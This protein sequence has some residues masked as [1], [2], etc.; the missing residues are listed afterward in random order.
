MAKVTIEVPEEVVNAI[1][2]LAA[3]K[4]VTY[5]EFCYVAF[6]AGLNK[7]IKKKFF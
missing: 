5:E 6:V 7:T 4:G 2:V 3:A 1:R